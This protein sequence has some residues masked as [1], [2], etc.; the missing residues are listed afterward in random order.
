MNKSNHYVNITTEESREDDSSVSKKYT[1]KGSFRG[2]PVN[3]HIDNLDKAKE[4]ALSIYGTI[5]LDNKKI[6]SY[7]EIKGG[8]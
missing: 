4:V 2:K 5:Y 8:K 6:I 1:V 3:A 7:I